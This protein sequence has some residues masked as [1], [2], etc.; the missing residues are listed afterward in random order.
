MRVRVKD[1]GCRNRQKNEPVK[2]LAWNRDKG[3]CEGMTS[4]LGNESRV[5]YVLDK[6]PQLTQSFVHNE[7]AELRRQGLAVDIFSLNPGDEVQEYVSADMTL[8]P[9]RFAGALASHMRCICQHPRRYLA[10]LTLLLHSGRAASGLTRSAPTAALAESGR[11]STH[12]HGHFAWTAPFV[13]ALGALLAAR[14]SVTAHAADIYRWPDAAVRSLNRLDEVVTVCEYNVEFLRSHGLKVPARVVCC[15]V[16][17]DPLRVED[18]TSFKSKGI[19][20]LSVGRLVPK[21][22]LRCPHQR[23]ARGCLPTDDGAPRHCR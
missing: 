19:D 6:W 11:S 12:V 20:V 10:F 15:G 8:S 22:G 14:T 2:Q 3:A 7:V 5:L 16:E 9:P 1:H 18:E 4:G 17:V 23:H 21:K 13:S